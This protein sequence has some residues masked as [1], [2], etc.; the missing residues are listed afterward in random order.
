MA[1]NVLQAFALRAQANF[2]I[3]ARRFQNDKYLKAT[4][5]LDGLGPFWHPV[6][7]V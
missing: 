3:V 1:S 5:R 6:E 4:L 7:L 2:F